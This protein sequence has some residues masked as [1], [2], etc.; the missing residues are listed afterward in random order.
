M[1][2]FMA[3]VESIIGAEE[4]V[5][6]H[7]EVIGAVDE[8]PQPEV[9]GMD[10]EQPQLLAVIICVQPHNGVGQESQVIASQQRS[11]R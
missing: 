3:G 8:Q 1:G 5:Q 11:R 2:G 4:E 7:P 9:I 10:D 6:P